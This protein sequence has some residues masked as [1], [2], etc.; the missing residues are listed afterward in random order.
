MELSA[1]KA[2][3]FDPALKDGTPVR[4]RLELPTSATPPE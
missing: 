1:A 3:Q 2:W 4:Y